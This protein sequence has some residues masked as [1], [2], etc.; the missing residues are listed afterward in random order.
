MWNERTARWLRQLSQL[1]IHRVNSA[2]TIDSDG[3]SETST[4]T[5][6][7]SWMMVSMTS[8][9]VHNVKS[10]ETPIGEMSIDKLIHS[11]NAIILVV[12][13]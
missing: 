8:V 1:E 2:T 6:I 7:P 3:N 10:L 9:S 5:T 4:M 12:C 11:L 13:L